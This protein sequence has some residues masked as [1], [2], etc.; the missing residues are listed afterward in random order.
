MVRY[1]HLTAIS[2]LAMAGG[3]GHV[4]P[5][6]A[7][8]PQILQYQVEHPTYGKIGTYTNTVDQ[9]GNDVDVQT[10]VRIAVTMLGISLFHQDADRQEHWQ[11]G[12]LVS[13]QSDTDDNGKK[14]DVSGTAQGNAFVVQS[15]LGTF[16]APAQVHPSN[17]W[18]SQ[19]LNTDFM[20][21][22]KTGRVMK[23]VVTDTGE[24]NI[25]FDGRTMRL[26]QYFIDGEKHQVVW[27]DQNGVVVAFQT[28]E[29][30]SPINFVLQRQPQPIAKN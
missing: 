2:L 19:L 6:R 5:A 24:T 10:E 3:L 21:S 13:Y 22:T 7:D 28:E 25:T 12:R 27:V 23:V 4:G 17:P 20:M 14:I 30:G 9:R 11:N 26:H 8:S 15:P 18:A 16:T 29:Q 1:T